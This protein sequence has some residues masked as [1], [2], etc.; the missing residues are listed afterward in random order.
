[1]N[2]YVV[3]TS[4][5]GAVLSSSAWQA[6]VL[7]SDPGQFTF[8]GLGQGQAAVLNY[9][10]TGATSI[11]SSKNGAIRGQPISI[12]ATGLGDIVSGATVGDGEITTSAIRLV[13]ATTRVEIDGQPVVVTYA[14]TSPGS[15]AGL[16]QINAI[17]PPTVTAGKPVPV[18]V[19]IGDVNTRRKSQ[20][21]VI[22]YI[23]K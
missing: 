21:N 5:L 12:Y 8:G 4:A 2:I 6:L 18:T 17:V 23:G 1:L 3:S 15:V 7:P 16:T 22:I 10:S 11:N 13:D 20:L 14:G 9:D 19:A